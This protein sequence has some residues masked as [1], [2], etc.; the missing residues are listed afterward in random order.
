MTYKKNYDRR[1]FL[2]EN[3]TFVRSPICKSDIFVDVC[4]DLRNHLCVKV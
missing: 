1:G 4:I 2:G 3:K